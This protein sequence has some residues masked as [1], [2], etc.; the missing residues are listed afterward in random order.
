MAA[1]TLIVFAAI[2]SNLVTNL[3]LRT[4]A[5]GFTVGF[6]IAAV[7]GSLLER[8]IGSRADLMEFSHSYLLW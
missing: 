6:Y 1:V 3:E 5:N 2:W 8:S 7:S 4:Y